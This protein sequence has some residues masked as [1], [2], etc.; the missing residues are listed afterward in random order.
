MY[1]VVT[2]YG[3]VGIPIPEEGKR[4]SMHCIDGDQWAVIR[5]NRSCHLYSR[6][7]ASARRLEV[8]NDPAHEHCLLRH[9]PWG[10]RLSRGERTEIAISGSMAAQP[11][12]P[13]FRCNF[14]GTTSK[15]GRIR[16]SV[17]FA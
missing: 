12:S 4:L 2:V 5:Q 13:E 1:T 8:P 16:D 10:M 9:G 17:V 7:E 14:P 6:L 15:L 3:T 11:T